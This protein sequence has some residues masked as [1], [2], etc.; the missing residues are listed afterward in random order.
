MAFILSDRVKESSTT[1]GNGILSL[2]GAITAFQSFSTGIGEGNE[3]YYAIENEARWEVGI[4]T[5][6]SNTLVRN[7][8]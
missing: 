7:T 1:T 2:D 3:T 6:T 5:Y 8:V 4:G